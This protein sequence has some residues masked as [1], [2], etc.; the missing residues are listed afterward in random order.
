[1]KIGRQRILSMAFL[2]TALGLFTAMHFLP[3]DRSDDERGWL[4]WKLIW[5][6]IWLARKYPGFDYLGLAVGLFSFLTL[7]LLIVASPFLGNV[8][9]KSLL[10][11]SVVVIFSGVAAAGFCFWVLGLD[12]ISTGNLRF[13]G[14]CLLIAPVLNF[15]GLLLAR[16]KWLQR[17]GIS[18]P[19]ES[20]AAV[21]DLPK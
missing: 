15:I 2:I 9:V 10:A 13:G 4:M 19:S 6:V 12:G 1:M 11:W 7:S 21:D 17:S 14:W 18:F 5:V 8:W 20:Q 16:P 3:V